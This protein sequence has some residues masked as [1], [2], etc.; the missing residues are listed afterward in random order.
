MNVNSIFVDKRVS[1]RTRSHG[2]FS[3]LHASYFS[4]YLFLSLC[5]WI[6]QYEVLPFTF[7]ALFMRITKATQYWEVVG[8][9]MLMSANCSA[10]DLD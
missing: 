9:Y 1:V 6:L 5:R 3:H 8:R 7:N 2:S 10:A 4:V